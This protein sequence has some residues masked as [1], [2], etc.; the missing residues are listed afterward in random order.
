MQQLLTKPNYENMK[1]SLLL[2]ATVTMLSSCASKLAISSGDESLSALTQVTDSEDP[3]VTPFGGDE[4]KNLFYASREN[5]FFFNI[6]KK[7]N[8]FSNAVVSKTSGNNQNYSPTY[9]EK[10]DKLAFRCQNEGTRT[11]DIYMMSASKGKA[12]T[13]ATDTPNAFEG[14]PSLSKDGKYLVYDKQTYLITAALWTPTLIEKSEIWLKNLETGESILLGKGYEPSFSPDSK[15]IAYVKYAADA[16]SCCIW[17]MDLD[18]GNQIQL[19]DA[20][21]GY[22]R[23]PKWSPDG[24]RIIFQ[25]T[26][27]DKK[28][29]DLYVINVD[30][31]NLTQLTKNKSHDAQP[32]WSND[33]SI[34]FTSDRG[35]KKGNYQIWRFKFEE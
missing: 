4:G 32:Y 12:M 33:G 13:Q 21:R 10:T 14:N 28:D 19:T 34:Y 22:A 15:Q 5:R 24:Q 8:A 25:S 6:Y 20:K 9:C 18:G 35:A 27:K 7:D 1:K 26:R 23:C 2:L 31:D 17:V 16:K 30:G 3:C 11:S 29:A